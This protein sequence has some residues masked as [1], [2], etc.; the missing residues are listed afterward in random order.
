M[1]EPGT[2]LPPGVSSASI[3]LKFKQ[4][5]SNEYLPV[6]K[7][8][9]T[10]LMRKFKIVA[11]MAGKLKAAQNMGTNKRIAKEEVERL[12]ALAKIT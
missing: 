10:R 4:N 7:V 6:K 9:V 5:G 3:T 2:S 11:L 1:R 12:S 8:D